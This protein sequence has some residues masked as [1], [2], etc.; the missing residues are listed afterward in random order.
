MAW[1]KQPE[2][3]IYSPY[4]KK[5]VKDIIPDFKGYNIENQHII[6]YD[7]LH[8]F[9]HYRKEFQE[10]ERNLEDQAA[11]EHLMFALTY[12]YSALEP[13]LYSYYNYVEAPVTIPSTD[14]PSLWM[15]FKPGDHV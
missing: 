13:E 10:Y 5:A 7:G 2:L 15:V 14:F 6:L 11:I 12:M 8:C 4:L 9:F 3:E 1:I